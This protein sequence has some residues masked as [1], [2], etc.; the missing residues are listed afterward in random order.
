M[1]RL[2]VKAAHAAA[3]AGLLIAGFGVSAALADPGNGN[4]PPSPPGQGECQ[5]GN[6][7]QD[8]TSDPQPGHGKE[9][10]EHGNNGG[11][12][13]DHCLGTTDS[14]T[15]TETTTTD[16]TTT[17]ETTTNETTTTNRT[18]TNETTTSTTTTNQT[19]TQETTTTPGT[20]TSGTPS[21]GFVPPAGQPSGNP[22][23]PAPVTK[24]QLEKA[25]AKQAAKAARGPAS[26]GETR[27][28]ELP[29]TGFPTWILTLVGSLMMATGLLVRRLSR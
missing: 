24:P 8:C 11:V 22:S 23:T 17:S 2:K 4:G 28:G 6:S 5:H 26:H 12:N 1:T 16:K 7:Q 29:F 18:T 19:T 21:G 3:M 14:T 15:T 10:D 20:T 27:P 13:E 25:L 9:C